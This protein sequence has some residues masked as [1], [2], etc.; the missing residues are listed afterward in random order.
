MYD[1]AKQRLMQDYLIYHIVSYLILS[2][3]IRY[4]FHWVSH[5]HTHSLSLSSSH[6][7]IVIDTDIPQQKSSKSG[8]YQVSSKVTDT[9]YRIIQNRSY[10][11]PHLIPVDCPVSFLSWLAGSVVFRLRA[12]QH[13]RVVAGLW[14]SYIPV[15]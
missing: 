10:C 6:G 14:Y 1:G 7:M 13:V 2:N 15:T 5:T 3:K 8:I 4:L 11:T 12:P 9:S